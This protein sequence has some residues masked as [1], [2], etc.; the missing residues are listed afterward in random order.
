MLYKYVT[1]VLLAMSWKI[2]E[3]S[4]WPVFFCHCFVC[5]FM[6][7]CLCKFT[8]EFRA[9]NI[10]LVVLAQLISVTHFA[11]FTLPSVPFYSLETNLYQHLR[12]TVIF[13]V[14][15]HLV[16]CVF[17]L[18]GFSLCLA[19]TKLTVNKQ[20]LPTIANHWMWTETKR[21]MFHCFTHYLNQF[22]FLVIFRWPLPTYKHT[23]WLSLNIESLFI[24]QF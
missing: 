14:T 19:N 8:V 23:S 18:L 21:D 10:T 3:Q 5:V 20:P 13:T 9:R 7:I 11:P 2:F 16:I 22:L 15:Y 4:Q 24:S 12:I 1:C 6:H 17:P